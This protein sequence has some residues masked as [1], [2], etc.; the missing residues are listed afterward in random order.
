MLLLGSL[1]SFIDWQLGNNMCLSASDS[2]RQIA[3]VMHG[4]LGLPAYLRLHS[5]GEQQAIYYD[6]RVMCSPYKPHEQ[7][8]TDA[9]LGH[10]AELR[11]L[12]H[13]E[14]PSCWRLTDAGLKQ[15]TGLTGLSHLDLSY[16]WQARALH[17]ALSYMSWVSSCT[18]PHAGPSRVPQSRQAHWPWA[19]RPARLKGFERAGE[20]C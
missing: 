1:L 11:A 18:C 13:L 2:S 5:S 14:L 7:A 19:A 8:V 10:C 20:R 15:L 9:G 3:W 6:D 17:S 12:R 16:C 4:I